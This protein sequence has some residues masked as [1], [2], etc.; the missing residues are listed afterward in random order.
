MVAVNAITIAYTLMDLVLDVN[1]LLSNISKISNVSCVLT[2][3]LT[4]CIAR[5]S[6]NV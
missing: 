3:Y 1:I 5:T 6:I 2:L 4:V